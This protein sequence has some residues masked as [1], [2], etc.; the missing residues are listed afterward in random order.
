MSEITENVFASSGLNIT[1]RHAERSCDGTVAASFN[2]RT[3]II[4]TICR[5][6]GSGDS[7]DGRVVTLSSRSHFS[8]G[9]NAA[10]RRG[11]HGCKWLLSND[12]Y[13]VRG[14]SSAELM[15]YTRAG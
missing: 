5:I 14:H 9:G 4:L 13:T 15:S 6:W 3:L 11:T 1:Q 2:T 10:A 7:Q 8:P 12:Y